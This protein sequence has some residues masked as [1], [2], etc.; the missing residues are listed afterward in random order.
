MPHGST[1]LLELMPD[2]PNAASV[3]VEPLSCNDW[4]AL[5]LNA[6][7]LEE[8][9]LQKAGVA[10]IESPLGVWLNDQPLAL[11][12]TATIPEADVVRLV[13]GT[14]ICIAPRSRKIEK[15]ETKESKMEFN[16][17][18]MKSAPSMGGEVEPIPGGIL[19]VQD[20]HPMNSPSG[21]Q[22]DLHKAFIASFVCSI[23]GENILPV[24]LNSHTIRRCSLKTGDR[25]EV[26]H[27]KTSD[28]R[29]VAIVKSCDSI[30]RGHI[31]FGKDAATLLNLSQGS[32][33]VVRRLYTTQPSTSNDEPCSTGS[34][35]AI[36][37]FSSD[38]EL[39]RET[40]EEEHLRMRAAVHSP[41]PISKI[42]DREA[43]LQILR[44]VLPILAVPPRRILQSWGAPRVGGVL[45]EG[46]AGSGKSS[47]LQSIS[48][49]MYHHRDC[50]SHTVIIKCSSFDTP[51]EAKE[52]ITAAFSEATDRMPSL[53]ILDDIDVICESEDPVAGEESRNGISE[54]LCEILDYIHESRGEWVPYGFDIGCMGSG[55]WPPL[56]VICSCKD[57]TKVTGRLKDI[58]RLDTIVTLSAP[59]MESREKILASSIASRGVSVDV[60][61][62]RAVA[63]KTEGFDGSDIGI[64]VDRALA[65]SASRRLVQE[66][67]CS[68]YTAQLELAIDD[69]FSS[70][71]GMTPAALWGTKAQAK[72]QS[73]V[74]G[75]Q[76]VGGL[77]LVRQSLHEAIELPLKYPDLFAAAPLRLRSG[78]LLY[79][80]PGCGKTHV[81]AAAVAAS[82]IRC[83]TVS[84]PE[85]LNK[86]I[87]A[88][89]A[90]VRDVFRRAAAAAPAVLFFDE[91]D[92]IAPQRGHDN[93]GVSDRVVNQLLTELDGV[94]VLHGVCVIAA[95]SRP[96]LID[97]ALLRPGRLDHLLLC[98]FPTESERRDILEALS[99][100]MSIDQNVDFDILIEHTEGWSGA[101]LGALLAE[102]QLAA[103]H[104]ELHKPQQFQLPSTHK[105]I[106]RSTCGTVVS[107]KHLTDALQTARPSVSQ[108]ERHKLARIYQSFSQRGVSGPSEGILTKKVT[109][110]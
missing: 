28:R 104:E 26:S 23:E 25:V 75:W 30:A 103:V 41:K 82:G 73:G 71:S 5:E 45:L 80:P 18:D 105:V 58:G 59:S 37:P 101:D 94:E 12:V 65:A 50:L 19:R 72:V 60:S 24:F 15:H 53:V 74:N 93:T 38:V 27:W 106:P 55:A 70:I 90:A 48:T 102:A 66:N 88:S 14:E 62:L 79:G 29:C 8:N 87:G 31:Y 91:F 6:E 10:S 100:G 51:N 76:D 96:D 34:A 3:T 77:R 17:S 2:V 16:P 108:E 20:A 95:T 46:P 84:G 78:V 99:R 63:A 42:F 54:W 36:S 89:E 44:R 85:L 11:R 35:A 22:D 64:L 33:V 43:A 83:I 107:S 81:V 47:L 86:Y 97:A 4:E 110:A 1:V 9:L 57:S 32:A 67:S 21:E 69:L 52:S 98:D 7:T 56:V 61:Q 49:L 109:W 40:A 92:S 39:K 13:P 68:N